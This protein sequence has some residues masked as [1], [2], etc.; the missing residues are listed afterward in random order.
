M[1]DKRKSNE[2]NGTRNGWVLGEKEEG[3]KF[4]YFLLFNVGCSIE[5]AIS[6]NN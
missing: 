6:M 2:A 1:N 4:D 3:L 5:E